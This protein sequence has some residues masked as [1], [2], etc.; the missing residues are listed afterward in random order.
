MLDAHAL[1]TVTQMRQAD[2]ASMASGRSGLMLMEA[3][4]QAVA[5]AIMQRWA[6][7]PVCVLCGPG[8]NGGDGWVVAQRLQSCG[9][10]VTVVSLVPRSSLQGDAAVVSHQ[11]SG[12][13]TVLDAENHLQQ[14]AEAWTGFQAGGGL[15]VD[16]L[17][18]AGLSRT[19]DAPVAGMLQQ[20]RM[21]ACAMVAV[22]VPSGVWGDS[23]E[24][25]GAPRC[26]L[27]VTFFRMKPAHVLMPS[28]G[29][30]GEVVVADIG[31]QPDAVPE[32]V[33]QAWDNHPDL[34]RHCWPALGETGHKYD[35]GHAVVW[36]GA[37][38]PGA[39]RLSARAAARI[40]AGLTTLCVPLAAWPV[41][42]AALD[43]IMVHGVPDDDADAMAE[44]LTCL[45]NDA[46]H[47]AVLVGP[48][49]GAGLGMPGVRALVASAL[50][51][52][53]QVVLDADALTAWHDAPDMLAQA[54]QQWPAREVVLTPH[55]G[56]F[57][58]LWGPI[59]MGDGGRLHRARWAA[60][61]MGAV[62][63]LKGPDT[64]VAAPDGRACVN[65]HASPTLAT[66]GAGDVL[67]GL[68]VGLLAQGMPAWEAAAAA[69]WVHGDAA[70]RLGRGLVADD[71]H[72]MVPAVL[73]A[74]WPR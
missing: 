27:T 2:Q 64:V 20:A 67:A 24:V 32:G 42:A 31:I 14:G 59:R 35:R 36:G 43:S 60:R 55:D 8:N 49:A 68:V 11:W 33:V 66:A 9:W 5:R 53:R 62:V 45:L 7:R 22:D 57:A 51:S 50:R 54:I 61:Q 12:P 74:L 38:M 16:A 28:R 29:Y 18:G 37:R 56:E 3:A 15:V 65:R 25:G 71:L 48:G 47:R 13:V 52:Q 40:G 23:G 46:R 41:H 21:H 34:W 72:G 69:V 19:L 63:V 6:P 1:L 70:L 44:G 30:C 73:Q 39:A 10:P 58:R 4:G 26:D 17:F